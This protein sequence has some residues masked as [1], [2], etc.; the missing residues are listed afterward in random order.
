MIVATGTLQLR[1]SPISS[2]EREG[3]GGEQIIFFRFSEVFGSHFNH[4]VNAPLFQLGH[5]FRELMYK[6]TI[7]DLRTET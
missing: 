4:Y 1:E 6:L 7:D 5:Y 2:G 3:G